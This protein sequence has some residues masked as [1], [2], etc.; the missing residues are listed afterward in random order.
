MGY[1][2]MVAPWMMPGYPGTGVAGIANLWTAV[3]PIVEHGIREF[4]AGVSLDHTLRETAVAGVLIGMGCDPMQAIAAVEQF[5]R[6]CP[7]VYALPPI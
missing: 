2:G 1:P 7:G 5:E 6:M 3:G 4:A